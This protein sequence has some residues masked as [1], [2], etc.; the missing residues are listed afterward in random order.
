LK[1]RC[2]TATRGNIHA[3]QETI[4]SN[5]VVYVLH[6]KITTRQPSL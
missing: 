3:F 4:Y 1:R 5:N 2:E 6:L